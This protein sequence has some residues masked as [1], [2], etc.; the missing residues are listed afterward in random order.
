MEINKLY[1]K[2]QL[3]LKGLRFREIKDL[4]TQIYSGN[5]KV[6]FFEIVGANKYR[7]FSVIS[8]KSL[9]VS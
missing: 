5:E 7:L 8:E 6:Y 4:D 1:T 3:E 2:D 9:Y